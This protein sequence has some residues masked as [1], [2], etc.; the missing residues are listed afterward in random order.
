M[1]SLFVLF[2]LGGTNV[3]VGVSRDGSN[4]D[5]SQGVPTPPKFEDGVVTIEKAA[6]AML[7]GATP[8]AVVGGVGWALDETRSRIFRSTKKNFLDWNDKPL[9]EELE[10]RLNA[11]VRLENDTALVGLGEAHVGAGKGSA[12][13]AYVTVSTGVNGARIIDGRVDRATYG[14]ETGKQ[15]ISQ[16]RLEDLVSGAAVQKKFGIHPKELDSL[17][18]RNKLADMLA[19]GLYNTCLHWSPDR[20]VLGGSMI[21]G[22]NPIPI[23]RTQESLARLLTMYPKA[24]E[25][26][27]AFLGDEGGL[28]GA[29]VLATTHP[30]RSGKF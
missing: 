28:Q 26:R 12:I 24:P 11:P 25:I 17:E 3:R 7:G 18:E 20:I 16:G 10:K 29:R 30:H 19:E 15:I 5:A 2:D 6:R 4:L 1:T 21:I 22:M 8:T 27:M 13:L 9:R 14:F 23:P